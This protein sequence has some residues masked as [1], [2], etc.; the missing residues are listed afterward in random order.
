[1]KCVIV[2]VKIVNPELVTAAPVGAFATILLPSF[3]VLIFQV[4][5]HFINTCLTPG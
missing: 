4:G 5:N 2:G 1:M 3:A